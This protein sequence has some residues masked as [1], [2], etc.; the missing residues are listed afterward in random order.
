MLSSAYA[1]DAHDALSTNKSLIPP[2]PT[3]LKSS[4]RIIA[5]PICLLIL[6]CVFEPHIEQFAY[7]NYVVIPN[8]LD[9]DRC[10]KMQK[11]CSQLDMTKHPWKWGITLATR[12]LIIWCLLCSWKLCKTCTFWNHYFNKIQ[13]YPRLSFEYI[14]TSLIQR[15]TSKF[16]FHDLSNL[17]QALHTCVIITMRLSI[18]IN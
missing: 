7:A 2:M 8:T 4:P 12:Q 15:S 9:N 14:P 3:S 17:V 18:D 1:N 10:L 5:I 13:R 6:R 16:A 11:R